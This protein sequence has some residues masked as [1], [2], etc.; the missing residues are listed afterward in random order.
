MK[1]YYDMYNAYRHMN[2][3]FDMNCCAETQLGRRCRPLRILLC[4][5]VAHATV[6]KFNQLQY[7]NLYIYI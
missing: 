7:L 1:L 5:F 4:L 6:S 2:N 3:H